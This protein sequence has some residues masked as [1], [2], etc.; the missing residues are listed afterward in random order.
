[1]LTKLG[2]FTNAYGISLTYFHL[3][4][5]FKLIPYFEFVPFSLTSDSQ[6]D[7]LGVMVEAD[8]VGQK[9]SFRE[10]HFRITGPY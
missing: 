4:C 5:S 2:H 6:N 9:T 7:G 3:K 8:V 10:K 1:M